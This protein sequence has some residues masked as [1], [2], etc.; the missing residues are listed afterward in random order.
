MEA[1][2]EIRWFSSS[3]LIN[4]Y[5]GVLIHEFGWLSIVFHQESSARYR[6]IILY[7]DAGRFG[8]IRLKM[9]GSYSEA[10][11]LVPCHLQDGSDDASAGFRCFSSLTAT[12]WG[13]LMMLWRYSDDEFSTSPSCSSSFQVSLRAHERMSPT[14]SVTDD[15]LFLLKS[16]NAATLRSRIGQWHRFSRTKS[17]HYIWQMLAHRGINSITNSFLL[18]LW[19]FSRHLL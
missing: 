19:H 17:L 10:R 13:F 5:F 7:N 15:A 14:I 3:S 11:L 2:H 8:F 6:C 1:W 9:S 12:K 18:G 4:A 16:R